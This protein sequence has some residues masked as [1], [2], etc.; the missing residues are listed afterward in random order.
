MAIIVLNLPPGLDLTSVFD[1]LKYNI[2]I[3]NVMSS[4]QK[5]QRNPEVS[6]NW[7]DSSMGILSSPQLD[8]LAYV[9]QW[10]HLPTQKKY[11]TTPH[12]I[13][14]TICSAC[15]VRFLKMAR[16]YDCA[17][18]HFECR[19]SGELVTGSDDQFRSI[20][21]QPKIFLADI[22]FKPAAEKMIGET[23]FL[24]WVE[25]LSDSKPVFEPEIQ[26][27]AHP[28]A[29]T[30]WIN[31][32]M[33]R[34]SLCEAKSIGDRLGIDFSRFRLEEFRRGL[35]IELA[36]TKA[37]D[38]GVKPDPYL[39]ARIVWAHLHETPDYYSRLD[40]VSSKMGLQNL[41]TA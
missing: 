21:I 19:V 25:A 28:V 31:E 36:R 22:E 6:L 34:F 18:T 8:T 12:L 32:D 41:K 15:M 17:I 14:A 30:I 5:K 26:V 35:E 4:Q 33:P 27:D 11:W 24:K 10:P 1:K 13:L 38:A 40:E 29:R 20:L 16:S 3:C 7:L 39:R 9:D 23:S 2:I 37:Q